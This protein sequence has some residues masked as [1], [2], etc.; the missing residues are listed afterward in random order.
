[1]EAEG[2]TRGRKNSAEAAGGTAARQAWPRRREAENT[3]QADVS[4]SRGSG[5]RAPAIGLCHPKDLFGSRYNCSV[6][7]IVTTLT[8]N[9]G[10]K[11]SQFTKPT[12]EPRARNHEKSNEAF[13]QSIRERLL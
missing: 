11:Q 5:L 6:L 3:E 10:V 1:M 7:V 2:R 12:S 8:T 9:Y 13:D 4:G